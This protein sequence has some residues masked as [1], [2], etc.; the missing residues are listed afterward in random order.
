MGNPGG[1]GGFLPLFGGGGCGPAKAFTKPIRNAIKIKN[2]FTI[3]FIR[4]KK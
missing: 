2:L 3:I 4:F 1:G